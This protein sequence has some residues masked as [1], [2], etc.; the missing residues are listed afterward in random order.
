MPQFR[1]VP[2]PRPGSAFGSEEPVWRPGARGPELANFR[3][4]VD[5]TFRPCFRPLTFPGEGSCRRSASA[6]ARSSG[7]WRIGFPYQLEDCVAEPDHRSCK[8][9]HAHPPLAGLD[10]GRVFRTRYVLDRDGFEVGRHPAFGDIVPSTSSAAIR[11]VVRV[12]QINHWRLAAPAQP[13]FRFGDLCNSRLATDRVFQFGIR[14]T[15]GNEK[16]RA[17]DKNAL[18]PF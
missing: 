17:G 11:F 18:E 13:S 3:E 6:A 8:K 7:D 4:M 5:G 10:S 2:L 16:Q 14:K 12:F 9:V 1:C 15:A